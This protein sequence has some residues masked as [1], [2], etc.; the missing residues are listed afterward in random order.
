MLMSSVFLAVLVASTYGVG[1][2]HLL[3]LATSSTPANAFENG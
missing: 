1:K 3:P 2:T